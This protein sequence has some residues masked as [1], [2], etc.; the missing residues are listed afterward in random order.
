ME[1]GEVA[2][3]SGAQ[4]APHP[5]EQL[6][7][8]LRSGAS[9]FYWIAGLSVVNSLLLMF[10]SDHNFVVG[11]GITQVF[12]YVATAAASGVDAVVGHVLR[13]ISLALDALA[14]GVFVLFGVLA[15]RRKGWAFVVGMGLY[16]LDGLIFLSAQLWM[17]V[18]FHVLALVGLWVGYSSLRKLRARDVQLGVRPIGPG[19]AQ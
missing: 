10:G 13:I 9:W 8:S 7:R 6:E 4:E 15:H 5:Q 16:S 19:A 12:D 18:A 2:T 3:L 11:L 17:N 14:V 1:P